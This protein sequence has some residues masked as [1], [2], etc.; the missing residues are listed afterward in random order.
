MLSKDKVEGGNWSH[1]MERLEDRVVGVKRYYYMIMAIRV[2]I[3][4]VIVNGVMHMHHC[5][6][7]ELLGFFRW[8]TRV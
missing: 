2:V 7:K 8:P 5:R 4:E 1:Y 3:E 6:C